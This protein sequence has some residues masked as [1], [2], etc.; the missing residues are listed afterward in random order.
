MDK[1]MEWAITLIKTV[2]SFQVN[3]KMTS[4]SGESSSILIMIIT[5]ASLIKMEISQD[6][7]FTNII[8]VTIIRASF[9]ITK[10]TAMVKCISPIMTV[11]RGND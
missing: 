10:N 8:R 6:K 11:T 5:R 3:I 7:E 4:W 9:W 1:K 2:L